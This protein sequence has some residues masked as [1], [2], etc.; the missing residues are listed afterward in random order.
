MMDKKLMPCNMI[1]LGVW[2]ADIPS[3]LVEGDS[4]T[5]RI[6]THER[7]NDQEASCLDCC[8]LRVEGSRELLTQPKER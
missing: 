1:G 2:A 6:C 8:A 3:E 4:I 7:V 5:V